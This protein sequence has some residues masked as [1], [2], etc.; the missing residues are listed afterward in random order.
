MTLTIDIRDNV[1]D[2]IL[3]FLNHFKDDVK[4]LNNKDISLENEKIL[5]PLDI[6]VVD[7]NDPDY[8]LYQEAKQRRTDGEKTYSL[9]EIMKEFQ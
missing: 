8:T 4:I 9:D 1:A 3:Y 6:E 2:K 5:E 7:K